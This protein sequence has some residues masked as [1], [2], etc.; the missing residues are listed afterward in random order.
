MEGLTICNLRAMKKMILRTLSVLVVA[1]LLVPGFSFARE[2]QDPRDPRDTDR[3]TEEE[4]VDIPSNDGADGEEGEDGNDGN[5]GRTVYV[6]NSIIITTHSG[7]QDES[8]GDGAEGD[9]SAHASVETVVNG[10]TIQDIEINGEDVLDD[11][12]ALRN[13]RRHTRTERGGDVVVDTEIIIDDGTET[14]TTEEA[15]D[16]GNQ[17]ANGE[18]GEDGEDGQDGSDAPDVTPPQ[19]EPEEESGRGSDRRERGERE[20]RGGIAHVLDQISNFVEDV[21]NLFFA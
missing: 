15:N 11:R 4:P 17:N 19:E 9:E 16:T 6:K 7:N 10:E 13:E 12:E 5:D 18:D 1:G 21:L 3:V 8:G 14:E 20:G 2:R